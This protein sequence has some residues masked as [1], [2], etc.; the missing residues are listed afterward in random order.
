[1]ADTILCSGGQELTPIAHLKKY[2]WPLKYQFPLV[3]MLHINY[4]EALDIAVQSDI[5]QFQFFTAI[6]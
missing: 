3:L 1:M 4:H 5:S 2:T 6:S